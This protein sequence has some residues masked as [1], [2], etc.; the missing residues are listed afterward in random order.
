MRREENLTDELIKQSIENDT[1]G[2]NYYLEN[3][4]GTLLSI[5][6]HT[7]LALDGDWGSGKTYFVRQL[8]YVNGLGRN[9]SY[10]SNAHS[11]NSSVVDGFTNKYSVFYF[12]AWQ[13][14]DLPAK[15]SILLALSS[16]YLD[17]NTEISNGLLAAARDIASN[18]SKVLTQGIIDPRSLR[19]TID[20]NLVNGVKDLNRVNKQIWKILEDAKE[21]TDKILLF[22]ID[23]LDRCKPTYA[24]E[25]LETIKHYFANDNAIF[26]ICANN[27]ELQH[28][29][30]KYYGEGFDGYKYLDRFY[31]IV[32]KLP[33]IDT[34]KYIDRY[35]SLGGNKNAF[36]VQ[37][38]KTLVKKANLPLRQVNRYCSEVELIS[39]QIT[40]S[41][42]LFFAE[43]RLRV[44]FQQLLVPF[45]LFLKHVS[46][47]KFDAFMQGNGDD[48]IREWLQDE[49]DHCAKGIT[50]NNS[51]TVRSIYERSFTSHEYPSL[52]PFDEFKAIISMMSNNLVIDPYPESN[53]LEDGANIAISENA[54]ND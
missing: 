50:K 16:F 23:D 34:E 31:D 38:V 19:Q 17:K 13:Y 21:K 9:F 48:L 14:D 42:D 22:I 37:V 54:S 27:S 4:L 41:R 1:I 32:F 53:A 6:R 52:V 30:K 47:E 25:L 39:K 43:Q 8:Q 24:V 12:N 5:S 26:L 18:I 40:N 29:I 35:F 3:F 10:G 15:E 11:I 2:R 49:F 36:H 28:T 46:T 33:D 20:E 44:G 51:E 7:I 45:A